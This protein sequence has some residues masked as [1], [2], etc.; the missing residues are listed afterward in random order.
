M[1]DN[2][3]RLNQ[4]AVDGKTVLLRADLNVP[5]LETQ[6]TSID[7]IDQRLRAT[8]PTIDYLLSKGCKIVLCS[9]LGRPG[10]VVDPKLSMKPI[11]DRLSILINKPI[12]CLPGCIGPD[13]RNTVE[14][15]TSGELVMLENLRFHPGEEKNDSGFATELAKLAD[16]FVL[17]AFGTAHRR[18]AS[19]VGVP[20]LLPSAPGILL[21]S[22]LS[23]LR[24]VLE[25]PTKP[26][27]AILGG[28]KISDKIKILDN[29]LDKL[30]LL[31]I[32]GGMA[33]NFLKAK[34]LNI[35]KSLVE[36][37]GEQLA[38]EIITRSATLK[39]ELSLPIDI[40]VGNEFKSAPEIVK[41]VAIDEI[42]DNFMILDIGPKTI[43][44]FSKQLS[45]SKTILWNGPLGVCEFDMF[46]KGTK[47]V[48][49]N[50]AGLDA[51]TIIGGGST[52]SAIEELGISDR[53]GYISTGGGAMLEF[54]EGKVLPGVSALSQHSN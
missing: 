28:A 50:L 45:R 24:K 3:L 5:I 25:T 42:E 26:L 47:N 32:G 33:S 7:M 52:A 4:L 38:R 37:D 21:Q 13:V 18:H 17:E 9:H 44:L 12:E 43:S 23:M 30:D 10:G 19:I 40:I 20:N 2:Y 29:L 35:G 49:E 41:T 27:A 1:K 36:D 34:G 6:G 8:I 31:V 15:M 48:A 14:A 46:S 22:E 16:V 51:F 39:V 11:A 53:L 54:L